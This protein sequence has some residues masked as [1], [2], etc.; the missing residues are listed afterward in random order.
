[1]VCFSEF[2][3]VFLSLVFEFVW[4]G[5][6]KKWLSFCLENSRKITCTHVSRELLWMCVYV[7]E[8]GTESGSCIMLRVAAVTGC[9][10]PQESGPSE[11]KI[12]GRLKQSAWSLLE[13]CSFWCRHCLNV[14]VA[15]AHV[16]FKTIW[17]FLILHFMEFR[18]RH[19]VKAI[20]CV[21]LEPC[22][23]SYMYSV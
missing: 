9:H 22:S 17:R 7:N 20:M 10:A 16:Q 13:S 15:V 6:R 4:V 21:P 19:N 8:R 18:L 12:T 2:W 5:L 11:T 14:A 3:V 1:M 23:S